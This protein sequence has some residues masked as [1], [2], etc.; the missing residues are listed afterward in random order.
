MK[1][2]ISIVLSVFVIAAVF[3]GCKGSDSGKV[4]LVWASY[5]RECEDSEMVLKEFNKQLAEVLP[6]TSIKLIECDDTNW[7]L[8]M[9]SKKPI[10]IAWTGY[11]FDMQNEINSGAYQPLDDLI[12][13]YAPN[14]QEEMEDYADDYK[15]GVYKGKQYMIPCQQAIMNQTSALTIPVSL[16]KYMDID[17][18]R[19]AADKSPTSTRELYDLVDSYLSKVFASSDYDT[20]VVGTTIDIY[21]LYQTLA[22]RGY[23]FVGS[24][25]TGPMLCYEAFASDPQIVSFFETDAF[26]LFCE[27]TAKWCEK[28]Y[29]SEEALLLGTSSGSRDEVL[30]GNNSAMWY[31]VDNP[32]T[33]E[34]RGVV[35]SV[36]DGEITAYNIL[37]SNLNNL[38]NGVNKFGYENTYLTIPFTAKHP[39]RAMQLLDLMR[40]EKGTPGNDL[41]NLLIYGFEKNSKEAKEYGTYHYELK[42]DCAYANDYVSQPSSD[43]KYGISRWVVGNTML[44]YRTP[45]ILEGQTEYCIDY[46]KNIKKTLYKTK[47]CGATVDMTDYNID[48]SNLAAV[49]TE[50]AQRVYYGVEKGNWKNV[51]NEMMTKLQA[52][53]LEAVKKFAQQQVDDYLKEK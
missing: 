21:S 33:G 5:S 24:T 25:R 6:N 32:E 43:S 19:A 37:L 40:S 1:R 9:S 26:K 18:V 3:A 8:Y 13:E 46:E 4:E 22:F 7:Q 42:G 51:Y 48:M 47:Y 17:A 36:T 2:F 20:D 10:D 39:E 15:S 35:Y 31:G 28:G 53:N 38:F 11:V 16:V 34:S 23:D 14:I 41:L 49:A 29:I 44:C 27:Y 50:Y 12:K 30:K 45:N 52:S